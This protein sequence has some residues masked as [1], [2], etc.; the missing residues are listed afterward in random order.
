MNQ[1]ANPVYEVGE[2][3]SKAT[4]RPSPRGAEEVCRHRRELDLPVEHGRAAVREHGGVVEVEVAV[5]E[6]HDP[7]HDH[8]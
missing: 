5:G 1:F 8:N 6:A 7:L 2:R 4:M 3:W